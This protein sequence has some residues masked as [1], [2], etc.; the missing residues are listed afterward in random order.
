MP[1]SLKAS[2][3]LEMTPLDDAPPDSWCLRV[4]LDAVE[5]FDFVRK[6]KQGAEEEAEFADVVR[7]YIDGVRKV[8]HD[9]PAVDPSLDIMIHP[10]EYCNRLNDC[11]HFKKYG[12][13]KRHPV[14]SPCKGYIPR[15]DGVN[16]RCN[17]YF[18]DEFRVTEGQISDKFIEI[19]NKYGIQLGNR[20]EPTRDLLMAPQDHQTN[21]EFIIETNTWNA[22]K[23][24]NTKV[25]ELGSN[26]KLEGIAVNFGRWETVSSQDDSQYA[27]DCHAHVH[28]YLSRPSIDIMSS[29]AGFK[30]LK[31]RVNH[32]NLHLEED[33]RL[34]EGHRLN[35]LENKLTRNDL[36]QLKGDVS[37]LKDNMSEILPILRTL[38]ARMPIR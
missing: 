12:C 22:I 38:D 33:C 24:I 28:L 5:W 10:G 19:A 23:G 1:S 11:E 26:S 15:A 30:G 25:E 36:S 16:R 9:M 35:P 18:L 6:N 17:F 21:R 4:K 32:P 31:G 2:Y 34:L 7:K 8:L 3:R 14:I 37:Q 27:L 13:N 29:D 20:R